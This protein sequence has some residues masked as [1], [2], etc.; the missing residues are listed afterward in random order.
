MHVPKNDGIDPSGLHRRCDW[1]WHLHSEPPCSRKCIIGG[2]GRIKLV[3]DSFQF[4]GEIR[5][6]NIDNGL[7]CCV[8]LLNKAKWEETWSAAG[9]VNAVNIMDFGYQQNFGHSAMELALGAGDAV[10]SV[11][12][13][14]GKKA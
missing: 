11:R 10:P 3:E 1:A 13:E 4:T 12:N 6:R 7:K 9:P 2:L 14:D 8:F 5:E